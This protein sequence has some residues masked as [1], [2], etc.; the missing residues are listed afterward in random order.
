MT[1]Y[2][3][4]ITPYLDSIRN[5]RTKEDTIRTYT[6]RLNESIDFLNSGNFVPDE[7]FYSALEA[8]LSENYQQSTINGWIKL[9]RRFFDWTLKHEALLPMIQPDS[10][11]QSNEEATQMHFSHTQEETLQA[12]HEPERA[13]NFLP[14]HEKGQGVQLA[15]DLSPHVDAQHAQQ[16]PLPP[17]EQQ[18][19]TASNTLHSGRPRKSDEP[20]SKKLSIYLTPTLEADV[21]DLARIQALST[22]D[23]IFRILQRETERRADTLATFRTLKED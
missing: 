22:P 1:D 13:V 15:T 3:S 14:P 9:T 12:E 2:K 20:R 11:S 8:H 19:G 5:E 10:S 18:G 21:K 6:R 23:Y 16:L 7:A 4:M 17:Q